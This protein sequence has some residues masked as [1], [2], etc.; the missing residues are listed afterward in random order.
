MDSLDPLAE[1]QKSLGYSF[2][3]SLVLERALTHSS[4]AHEQAQI[5][6]NGGPESNSLGH[7][8]R[9]EF[10]GDAVLGLVVSDL[11]MIKFSQAD[12][13][14][15]SRVRAGLVNCDRLTDIARSINLGAAI[16]VG[17]GEESTGGRDKPSILA[18]VFEA[19]LAAVYLD[20]GFEQARVVVTGLFAP[21][22]ESLPPLDLF[23]DYKT[24][25]QEKVQAKFKTTPSYRVIDEKG[26]DHSKTFEVLV[27]ISG[28][29]CASG[30][31]RSKKEAEQDAAKKALDSDMFDE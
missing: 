4:Y 24:P 13:G 9:L 1:V 18:A 5:E 25:L 8:E 29:P 26:P 22:I 14:E 23:G 28:S 31:G 21:L 6:A 11:V 19:V 10:L 17:K 30:Q 3:D 27:F 12:E 2:D 7:Y 15:L 16:R 20:G